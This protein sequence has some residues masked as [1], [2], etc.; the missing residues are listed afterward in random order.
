[1]CHSVCEC[2]CVPPYECVWR[3]GVHNQAARP[4]VAISNVPRLIPVTQWLILDVNEC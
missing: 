1:M 3:G 4:Y 2:A